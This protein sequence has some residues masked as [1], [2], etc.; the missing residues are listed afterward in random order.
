MDDAHNDDAAQV[1]DVTPEEEV[2]PEALEAAG[3]DAS[4]ETQESD[5]QSAAEPAESETEDSEEAPDE[6]L[7]EDSSPRIPRDRFDTALSIVLWTLVIGILALGGIFAYS[8]YADRQAAALATPALRLI[9]SLK[10]QVRANP[11]EVVL[12]V[13]L[14]EALAAAGKFDEAVEQFENALRIDENHTGAYLDLGIV[15]LATEDH[16]AAERYLLRVVELT[17]DDD[18]AGVNE[19][20]ELA[21][22]NLGLLSIS[23]KDYEDA[24]GYLKGA[25]RIRRD[26]SD[27]YYA[28][29]R[30]FRG[31]GE[32]E[33][34]QQELEIALA[35]DPNYAAAHFLMGQLYSEQDDEVNA[36]YHYQKAAELAPDS[37][38]AQE[39]LAAFGT[40]EERIERGEA[41]L[42]EGDIETALIEA[43]V[44]RNV[45]PANVTPVV[46]HGKVLVLRGD[47]AAAFEV[48]T[49]A[50][51]LS[52]DDEEIQDE[53]DRLEALV[54]EQ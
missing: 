32:L 17:D 10:D 43:L 52:P 25:T 23:S 49:E 24:L 38:P 31:L 14:G 28:M 12:R 40:A 51:E 7:E 6:D 19:R 46:F 48:Y 50:L 44:A 13:R 2:A 45:E 54:G 21:L 41:A 5:G 29:A 1:D 37:D 30:A 36:S 11:N 22:Y 34:A 33:A 53:L 3:D 4:P 39:A 8:V 18:M 35:F 27:S 42:E 20:R 47:D 9:D 15:A 26:A 16:D